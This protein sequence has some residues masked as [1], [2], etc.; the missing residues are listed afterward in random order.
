MKIRIDSAMHHLS[1]DKTVLSSGYVRFKWYRR[2]IPAMNQI[3]ATPTIL[4]DKKSPFI[5]SNESKIFFIYRLTKIQHIPK[6]KTLHIFIDLSIIVTSLSGGIHLNGALLII[7]FLCLIQGLIKLFQF[8]INRFI[9]DIFL[10]VHCDV[11]PAKNNIILIC[12]R[13]YNGSF[14]PAR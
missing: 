1:F 9:H 11:F 4:L 13:C 3:T 2:K 14:A 10:P 6:R 5:I 7:F 8:R 12:F